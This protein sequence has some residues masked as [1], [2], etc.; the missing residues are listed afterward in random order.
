MN[1]MKLLEKQAREY[2]KEGFPG[3]PHKEK[4]LLDREVISYS[5][6]HLVS[7]GEAFITVV[8]QKKDYYDTLCVGRDT[9]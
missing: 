4:T 6:K 1:G 7:M 3:L 9:I 8:N 5:I 2:S